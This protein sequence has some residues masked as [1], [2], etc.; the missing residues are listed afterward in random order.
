[1]TNITLAYGDETGPEMMEAA[2]L[3]LRE[4]GAQLEIET[5]EIGSRVYGMGGLDGIRPSSWHAIERCRAMLAAPIFM[6]K[7]EKLEHCFTAIRKRMGLAEVEPITRLCVLASEKPLQVDVS[8]F[9][10]G[11]DDLVAAAQGFTGETFSLFTPMPHAASSPATAKLSSDPS[12]MM[13]AAVLMLTHLGQK[14][15]ADR[16]HAAWLKALEN[17]QKKWLKVRPQTFAELVVENL[18]RR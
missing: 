1:M 12:D 6:P 13:Q 14:E 9:A 16:I 11:H 4:A 7:D 18:H 2:L 17:I 8:Y 3:V 5:I 10:L 15:T